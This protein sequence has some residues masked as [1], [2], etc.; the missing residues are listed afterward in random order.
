M[1]EARVNWWFSL[2]SPPV[3][4]SMYW[5]RKE[6]KHI[7]YLPDFTSL[8]R[9]LLAWYFSLHIV[10][11]S[12]ACRRNEK[13]CV[14]KIILLT[15]QSLPNA[16]WNRPCPHPRY[17]TG[18]RV[19]WRLIWGNIIKMRQLSFALD[20]TP[21]MRMRI[22]STSFHSNNGLMYGSKIV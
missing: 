3:Y 19:Q 2:F 14:Q 5:Y 16:K 18:T 8:K 21:R 20:K 13:K 11:T 15:G 9:A 1:K 12:S 10:S 22:L 7:D 17:G 6:K 4:V